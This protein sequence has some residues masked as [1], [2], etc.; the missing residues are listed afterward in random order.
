MDTPTI[1]QYYR[2]SDP[3]RRLALL[4][5]SI[6]AGEEPELNQ[7]R[8]ELWDIRYQDPSELGGDTRAD[9]FIAL[10]MLMEFN[11]DSGKRFMGVR[12]GRKEIMK[13]LNK[14]KF[15]E[16]C[17]KGKDYE[18][19]LYRECKHLVKFYMTLC[20][21]D[22]NYNSILCGL[23]TIKKESSEAKMKR[24]IYETAIRLPKDLNLEE[25]LALVTKAAHEVYGQEYPEESGFPE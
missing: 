19:L 7:I 1:T 25:E 20:A 23:I 3:A 18:E 13:Q 24:D 16:I 2:E 12:G 6:E 5:M 17:A 4:N 21:Q 8:R 22:K 10:W 15:Q 14:M 9:G 11:I